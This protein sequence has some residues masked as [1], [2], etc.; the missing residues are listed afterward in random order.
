MGSTGGLRGPTPRWH[1]QDWLVCIEALVTATEPEATTPR[2]RRAWTLIETIAASCGVE[3]TAYLFETDD[4]WGPQT[5][6]EGSPNA[7]TPS[8][9]FDLD[10]WTLLQSALESFAA[11]H[12]HT[13][14]GQRACQLAAVIDT[15]AQP[16]AGH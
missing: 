13:K 14:R 1:R 12:Q 7:P 10:D 9:G 5:A 16:T 6:V 4:S 2:R 11:A 15:A 8:A 3:P